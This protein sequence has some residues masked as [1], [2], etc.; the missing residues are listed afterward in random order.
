MRLE[1]AEGDFDGNLYWYDLA[2]WSGSRA[3]SPLTNCLDGLF[4]EAETGTFHHLNVRCAAIRC[5]DDHQHDNA[6][7]FCFAGFIGVLRIWA[8]DAAGHAHAVDARAERAATSASTFTRAKSAAGAASDTCAVTVTE[9]IADAVSERIAK[10][11]RLNVCHVQIRRPKQRRIHRQFWR[12]I[13][14]MN[15]GRREL[16]HLEFRQLAFVHRSGGM[17]VGATAATGLFC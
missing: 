5:D 15:L 13:H 7:I 6:L 9:G 12:R 1:Q 11:R 8:V 4:V 17:V 3:K 2:A 10:G 16:G 14:N